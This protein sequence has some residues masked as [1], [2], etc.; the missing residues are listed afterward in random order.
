MK[1]W[2]YLVSVVLGAACLILA[3]AAYKTGKANQ[4]LQNELQQS[5]TEISRGLLSQQ[6]QQLGNA[7]LQ[8][9]VTVAAGNTRVHKLLGDNGYNIQFQAATNAPT[10]P[11]KKQVTP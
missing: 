6:G 2:Q 4:T 7:I 8:D 1:T 3:L 5:Q 9:M 11:A 10:A